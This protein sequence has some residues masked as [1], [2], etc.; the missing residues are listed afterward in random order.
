LERSS[1]ATIR[2]SNATAALIVRSGA[3]PRWLGWSAAA[4]APLLIANAFDLGAE[5]GPAFILFLLWTLVTAIVLLRRAVA[6]V[7]HAS[8]APAGVAAT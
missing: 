7:A 2:R 1:A 6:D 3:L 8:P 4:I 5:F